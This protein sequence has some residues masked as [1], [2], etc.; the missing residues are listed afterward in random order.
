MSRQDAAAAP[1]PL[2]LRYKIYETVKKGTK[3]PDENSSSQQASY[4]SNTNWIAQLEAIEARKRREVLA[5]VGIVVH[6]L[7]PY[8]DSHADEFVEKT[9]QET[10]TLLRL[11]GHS[12][13]SE[14]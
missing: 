5:F 13:D 12:W 2:N 4:Y 7:T 9:T 3:T 1:P 14:L 6:K 8:Q 10:Q 11:C